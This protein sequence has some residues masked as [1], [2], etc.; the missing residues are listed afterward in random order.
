LSTTPAKY[1][2]FTL[3]NPKDIF[4][5]H[6]SYNSDYLRYLSR[7]QKA[8]VVLRDYFSVYYYTK[9]VL[10]KA[11]RATL[12]TKMCNIKLA[13]QTMA[14]ISWCKTVADALKINVLNTKTSSASGGLRPLTLTGGSAP[15]TPAGGSAPDPALTI[16]VCII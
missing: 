6:Y 1:S 3:E 14:H 10:L 2:H 9:C 4:Q 11:G 12:K 15:W 8:T 16:G 13:T 5:H 7:K